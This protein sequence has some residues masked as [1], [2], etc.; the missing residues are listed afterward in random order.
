MTVMTHMNHSDEWIFLFLHTYFLHM[1]AQ[2]YH[3]D[4]SSILDMD[5]AR[6]LVWSD[7]SCLFCMLGNGNL[8]GWHNFPKSVLKRVPLGLWIKCLE[9]GGEKYPCGDKGKI[10]SEEIWMD[11]F[12]L[13]PAC[14][15]RSQSNVLQ[16]LILVTALV[17]YSFLEST[18]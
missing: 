13:R 5:Y 7:W 16:T 12:R 1:E 11:T 6:K 15:Q 17:W 9:G 10:P 18:P 14:Q 4:I 8:K 3:S 2:C